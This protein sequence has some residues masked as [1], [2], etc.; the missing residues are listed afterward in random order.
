MTESRIAGQ[1]PLTLEVEGGLH[2]LTVTSDGFDSRT[3]SVRITASSPTVKR[4]YELARSVASVS[5]TLSPTGGILLLDGKVKSVSNNKLFLPVETRHELKYSKDG[6]RS[7]SVDF[8]VKRK[9][10]NAIRIDLPPVYGLVEV[11]SQPQTEI[12]INGKVFG[13]TPQ[14]LKMHAI[15]QTITLNAPGF[16][17]QT[18]TIIPEESTRQSV[19]M[20]LESEKDYR[21]RIAQ[22][23]YVNS[24]GIEMKLFDNLGSITLGSPRGEI[25]RRANEF[26]REV[27]LTRPFYAGVHEVTVE[28]FEKFSA[29]GQASSGNRQPVTDIGWTAAAKFCNWLSN[30]EGFIPVYLFT[31]GQF[32]GSNP[33]ADGY[34][35]L[36]E[37]EWEWLA[38]KAGR[39]QQSKFP[40]GD[41]TTIPANS[42]NFADESAKG[43]LK[44]YIRNYRDGY[45][46]VSDTGVF[47]TNPAGLH[48][49][50]GNV[51]E[52][53]HDVYSLKPPEQVQIGVDALDSGNSAR[54]VI[55]GSSWKSA[56]L[57]ELRAS[58]RGGSDSANDDVGF[59]VARYLF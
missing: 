46:Q 26:L 5:L 35:M 15:S 32:A 10:S 12:E 53:T 47:D 24:A 25:G 16:L 43:S 23:R 44:T 57:T 9:G 18:R 41:T 36:T 28:Q 59:R 13:Q 54:H 49:L 33:S 51:K 37:A 22:P 17:S 6:F 55:K 42:G 11:N 48:D 21:M 50:A 56:E 20:T 38:R 8:T 31:D 39:T 34:R 7:Q 58:W 2:D 14:L 40:W 1:T 30:K 45:P 3:D 4:H 52:W 19:F 27:R 29:S